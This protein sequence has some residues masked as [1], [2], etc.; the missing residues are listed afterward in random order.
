[1]FL[2]VQFFHLHLPLV[3]KYGTLTTKPNSV[4]SSKYRRGSRWV[5]SGKLSHLLQ[6]C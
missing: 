3:V 5:G 2:F 6:A 4:V 1:M